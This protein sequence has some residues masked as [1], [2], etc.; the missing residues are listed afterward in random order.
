MTSDKKALWKY[1]L[2]ALVAGVLLYFSFRGVKWADFLAAVRSCRPGWLLLAMFSGVL[3]FFVRAL[4]WKQIVSPIDSGVRIRDTFNAVN[5]SYLVNLALP[6]V[7]ELVRCGYLARH[8]PG[9]GYDK[10]LGTVV[11]ERL[12]DVLMMF[13]L[14]LVL[15]WAMWDRFGS[16][17]VEKM[18]NPFSARLNLGLGGI[19]LI[20][21]V[22]CGLVLWGIFALRNRWKP[23]GLVWGFVKGLGQGVV[24]CFRMERWWLFLLYSL[25]LWGLYWLM[26]L[27]VL[28]SVQGMGVAGTAA[29]ES[30]LADA[31]GG[32]AGATGGLADAVAAL[33]SLGATDALFLMLAGSLSSLVP[34]PGGF[35]AF[36]Y[37]VAIALSTVYGIPF[38]VG[39]IF[40]TLSHESQTLT[41][42]VC[43]TASYIDETLR[44]K[45][46]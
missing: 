38:G 44:R 26:S 13:I 45:T 14:V 9:A 23:A 29:L 36:H 20:L 39:I 42:I 41:M 16:F 43:G 34:V 4:R 46:V 31:A 24:S 12:W 5:I 21:A 6:R 22:F 25:A 19:V 11:L 30:G 2:S 10:L 35:G 18:L 15:A 17:F 8:C 37:I 7:G 1:I 32:L 27:S 33:A 28:Y 3:S 40:A